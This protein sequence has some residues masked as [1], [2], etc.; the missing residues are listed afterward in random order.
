M[1]ETP[2]LDDTILGLSYCTK[3][4][5][6]CPGDKCPFHGSE[7]YCRY[8]LDL[9]A[10]PHLQEYKKLLEAQKARLLTLDEAKALPCDTDIWIEYL[11]IFNDQVT[12]AATICHNTKSLLTHRPADVLYHWYDYGKSF[13]IWSGRPT[14]EQQKA[15]KWDVI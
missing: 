1:H 4:D 6:E 15:V 8:K 9:A 2:S 13:V 5:G 11:N 14:E 3:K 7:G 12:Y 10:L